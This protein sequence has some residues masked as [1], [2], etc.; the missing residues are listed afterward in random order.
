MKH[1]YRLLLLLVTT[2]VFVACGPQAP[3]FKIKGTIENMRGG[4]LYIYNLNDETA[5]IDTIHVSDG[6][7]SYQG[8][9]DSIVPYILVYPNAVEQV[10]FA[11]GGKKIIYEASLNDL[12]HYVVS[13][14]ETNELMNEF[15]S[16]TSNE[17]S[18][19]KVRNI[20]AHY[21]LTY[22]TSHVAI[23]LLDHYFMQDDNVNVEQVKKMI[24]TIKLVQPDNVDIRI[25]ENKLSTK[26][27]GKVGSLLPNYKMETCTGDSVRLNGFKNRHTLLVFW[28]SWMHD[29]YDV[30]DAVKSFYNKYGKQNDV[31]IVSIS[32]DGEKYEWSDFVREDTVT[33][34]H[35]YDGLTWESPVVKELGVMEIPYYILADKKHKVTIR[36][37]DLDA[38]QDGLE[39]TTP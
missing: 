33:M 12:K 11:E 7:F 22:P 9:A 19:T 21:I 38:L 28:A 17:K 6:K 10:I 18:N 29:A 16:K 36:D 4:D 37:N 15:R 26:E 31:I 34:T 20:A 2:S 5:C 27:R 35:C 23:Y 13:G 14:T 1:L 24:K 30:F 3:E 32:L 25:M 8:I 39:P